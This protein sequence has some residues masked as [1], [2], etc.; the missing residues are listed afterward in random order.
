MLSRIDGGWSHKEEFYVWAVG[1]VRLTG[2]D[3]VVEMHAVEA[4]GEA[5]RLVGALGEA[6]VAVV[7]WSANGGNQLSQPCFGNSV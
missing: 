6:R 2:A 4:K 7:T 3:V 1:S 5:S